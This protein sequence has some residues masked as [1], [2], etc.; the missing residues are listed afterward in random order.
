MKDSLKV[1]ILLVFGL[2]VMLSPVVYGQSAKTPVDV[3]Q[4]SQKPVAVDK[5]IEATGDAETVR[6]LARSLNDGGVDPAA[7]NRTLSGAAQTGNLEGITEVGSFVTDQV[8]AG[9]TGEEL[10]GSIHTY[11]NENFGIPAGGLE[12]EGP[13]PIANNFIPD[14]AQNQLRNN[15]RPSVSQQTGPSNR[16]GSVGGPPGRAGPPAGMES[17]NRQG[18][19]HSRPGAP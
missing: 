14:K 7:F 13:P 19:A 2:S 3:A 6:E 4:L 1:S 5:L 15:R 8:E 12:T 9:V 16:P 10:A 18:E 11:L 17:G